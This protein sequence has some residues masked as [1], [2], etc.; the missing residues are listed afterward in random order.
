MRIPAPLHVYL[1][2]LCLERSMLRLFQLL[3]G[4]C[5]LTAQ[6]LDAVAKFFGCPLLALQFSLRL[7]QPL[8]NLL[9][10]LMSESHCLSVH[11]LSCFIGITD[12]FPVLQPR[13]CPL[14]IFFQCQQ[15]TVLFLAPLGF[16][17]ELACVTLD[18][19]YVVYK[20][21][22]LQCVP[23]DPCLIFALCLEVLHATFE[24]FLFTE[25]PLCLELINCDLRH[26]SRLVPHSRRHRILP[27]QVFELLLQFVSEVLQA[28]S[29][30]LL[31]CFM[32]PLVT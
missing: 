6:G 13:E 14:N 28:G 30:V 29:P 4:L 3:Q 32:R 27:P 8:L 11:A 18:Y 16:S 12:V 20:P 2:E 15:S 1:L 31:E 25:I 10:I 5:L 17:L 19:I 24:L 9:Q 7:G 21:L 23:I 26:V 22:L